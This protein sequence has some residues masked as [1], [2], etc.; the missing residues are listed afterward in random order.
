MHYTTTFSTI[1]KYPDKNFIQK[2]RTSCFFQK[3]RIILIGQN[4]K[5]QNMQHVREDILLVVVITPAGDN[6]I[7]HALCELAFRIPFDGFDIGE[8]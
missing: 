1:C 3:I 2:I 4:G 7:A 6:V 8:G 5:P